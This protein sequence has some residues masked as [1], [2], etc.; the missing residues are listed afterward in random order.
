MVV[1]FSRL[2]RLNLPLTWGYFIEEVPTLVLSVP[3][4]CTVMIIMMV[5]SSFKLGCI[6][7]PGVIFDACMRKHQRQRT[8]SWECAKRQIH[9]VWQDQVCDHVN[10]ALLMKVLVSL[11]S[12]KCGFVSWRLDMV[13]L[14][15]FTSL[16]CLLTYFLRLTF[17]SPS[18][19][20]PTFRPIGETMSTS[21]FGKRPGLNLACTSW[22]YARLHDSLDSGM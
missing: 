3:S 2:A 12:S 6:K 1:V 11:I 15:L 20:V 10:F 14:F 17:L 21:K 5:S 22:D 19:L 8:P 9:G 13:I 18:L 7:L 16:A 4:F